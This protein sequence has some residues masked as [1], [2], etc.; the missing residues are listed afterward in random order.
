MKKKEQ[1]EKTENQ[2]SKGHEPEQRR[3]VLDKWNVLK[4]T[5]PTNL[6]R[7]QDETISGGSNKAEPF[8]FVT[9]FYMPE[10]L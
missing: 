7:T 1:G 3:I 4:G 8:L 10:C 2:C 6:G 5:N 9:A